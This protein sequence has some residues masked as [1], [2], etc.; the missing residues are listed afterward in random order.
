M[1]RGI[2]KAKQDGAETASQA[3]ERAKRELVALQSSM[4]DLEAAAAKEAEE[5][6]KR[7]PRTVALV[8]AFKAVVA[9]LK[10]EAPG[11]LPEEVANL[12]PQKLPKESNVGKSYG[13]SETQIHGAKEKGAKAIE[14]L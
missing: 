14:R 1:P 7:G 9:A 11:V 13:L 10:A 12:I 3:L 6:A 8:G 4:A 2:P 5:L